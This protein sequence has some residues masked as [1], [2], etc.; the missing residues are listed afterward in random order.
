MTL[1]MTLRETDGVTVVAL[2]GRIVLGEEAN[3]LRDKVK[4]LLA[5]GKR[6]LLLDMSHVTLI[7]SAGLGTLVGAHQ[8]AISR[9]ASVRFCSLGAMLKELLQMTRLLTVFDVSANEA[10][11]VLAF[12]AGAEPGA[13]RGDRS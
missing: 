9:G 1:K 2:D 5:A 13:G 4:E 10:D 8:S 12:S 7:D 6:K 3:S 11:A